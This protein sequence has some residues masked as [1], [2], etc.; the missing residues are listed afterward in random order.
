MDDY[1]SRTGYNTAVP[2]NST[3]FLDIA[4]IFVYFL[5]PEKNSG[6]SSAVCKT[7]PLPEKLFETLAT[8]FSDD[9]GITHDALGEILKQINQTL[10]GFLHKKDVSCRASNMRGS[11]NINRSIQRRKRH[12]GNLIAAT[13]WV[14]VSML[15]VDTITFREGD[16]LSC[17]RTDSLEFFGMDAFLIRIHDRHGVASCDL[18]TALLYCANL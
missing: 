18:S 8:N 17:S 4:P 3:Q 15:N 12:S 5:L 13:T 7:P 10:G 16:P 1:E 9:K 2:L 14:A 6:P 11:I